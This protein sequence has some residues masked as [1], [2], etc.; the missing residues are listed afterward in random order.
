[1][2]HTYSQGGAYTV[3]LYALGDNGCYS[4]TISR[5]I[6]IYATNAF[7]GN[8]TVVTDNHPLPLQ[9]SGGLLYTWS[10]ADGLSNPSIAN[11]I[12]LIKKSTAYVLTAYTPMGCASTD[13]INI[14]VFKGPAI[15][16]PNV[17]S[18]NGDRRN[19]RFRMTAVGMT[20]I[21]F[22]RIYNRYGQLVYHS[23]NPKEGWDGTIKGQPQ[24]TGTYVWVVRGKDFTGR[25]HDQKGA[26]MLIR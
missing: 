10:P 21:Y 19:D 8:D 12:A 11:P 23:T 1:M 9:G 4:D 14:K 22:F 6:N 20:D 26:F 16:I 3:K 2:Q 13:T 24:P 15:Y 18:P 17:F 7:A 25:I 5:L